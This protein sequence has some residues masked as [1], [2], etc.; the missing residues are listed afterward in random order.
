MNDSGN[1]GEPGKNHAIR[2]DDVVGIDFDSIK[3]MC[4][5]GILD[6]NLNISPESFAK[7][8]ISEWPD[9]NANGMGQSLS[10][11]YD[12]VKRTGLPNALGAKCELPTNLNI[13]AWQRL[14]GN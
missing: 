11:I 14:L 1:S 7:H 4:Q 13:P 6:A 3:K 12:N 2:N 9:I 8:R 10:D 5:T